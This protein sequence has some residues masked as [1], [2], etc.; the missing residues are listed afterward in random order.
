MYSMWPQD[1]VAQRNPQCTWRNVKMDRLAASAADLLQSTQYHNVAWCS[2]Y[3]CLFELSS[4]TNI[5]H[6]HL[7]HNKNTSPPTILEMYVFLPALTETCFEVNT[8]GEFT[9]DRS[10][11]TV[12]E[13][14]E[15]G[16]CTCC[17]CNVILARPHWVHDCRCLVLSILLL[18]KATVWHCHCLLP[19]TNAADWTPL[20]SLYGWLPWSPY[21]ANSCSD[22]N[23]KVVLHFFF[24]CLA[25]T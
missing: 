6:C 24:I 21:V 8:L 13:G 14:I 3:E 5:L 17:P 12:G 1:D 7:V 18:R 15:G 20:E 2:I 11:C 16:G 23:C 19:Q 22:F 25:P 10:V 9:P 4:T